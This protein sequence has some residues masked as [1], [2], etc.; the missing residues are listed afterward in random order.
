MVIY[1]EVNKGGVVKKIIDLDATRDRQVHDF[2]EWETIEEE[3][4]EPQSSDD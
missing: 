3:Y 1:V 2:P 4:G